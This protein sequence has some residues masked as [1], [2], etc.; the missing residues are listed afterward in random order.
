MALFYSVS[1]LKIRLERDSGEK[2]LLWAEPKPCCSVHILSSIV[3]FCCREKCRPKRR[4]FESPR[5]NFFL[6]VRQVGGVWM[7]RLKV[8]KGHYIFT[9]KN[10][11][12]EK[13][14]SIR[15]HHV[16]P[17]IWDA[18]KAELSTGFLFSCT[19]WEKAIPV[20]L[21]RCRLAYNDW[22][23]TLGL[24]LILQE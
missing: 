24:F 18:G 2:T 8:R 10:K 3:P 22:V 7:E 23:P 11:V 14:K 1:S 21:S 17:G 4:K 6:L 12:Q 15:Y 5:D 16:R 13:A 19:V 9:N 20:L